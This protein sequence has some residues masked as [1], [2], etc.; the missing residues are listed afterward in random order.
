MPEQKIMIYVAS[1]SDSAAFKKRY[2]NT[3]VSIGTYPGIGKNG[4]FASLAAQIAKNSE[5]IDQVI[6]DIPSCA[7]V[8]DP[9]IVSKAM[10]DMVEAGVTRN[11]GFTVFTNGKMLSKGWTNYLSSHGV[12][13]ASTYDEIFNSIDLSNGSDIED[14]PDDYVDDSSPR[15]GQSAP[16][17]VIG[18]TYELDPF[19]DLGNYGKPMEY[20][21]TVLTSADDFEDP[22]DTDD[23][24]DMAEM[25]LHLD[26]RSARGS[27]RQVSEDEYDPFVT[28]DG[29]PADDPFSYL[30]EDEAPD[31][32]T[33]SQSDVPSS[34]DPHKQPRNP[35]EWYDGY[36]GEFTMG[37][38]SK[39]IRKYENPSWDYGEINQ[40]IRESKKLFGGKKTMGGR[41]IGEIE[42]DM[43]A[44]S[45]YIR[46]KVSQNGRYNVPTQSKIITVTS[47]VGAAGKT[48]ITTMIGAQL[49]WYFNRELLTNRSTSQNSRVLCLSLNEFDDIPVKG[50]GY[51]DND[52]LVER[53]PDA[54][55]ATLLQKIDECEGYPE[56]GDISGCFMTSPTNYVTYLPSLTMRQ[57]FEYNI[58]L[59]AD[60]YLKILNVCRRFFNF[61]V[62]DTPDVFFDQRNNLVSFAFNNSDVLC[63]VIQPDL[64]S[65]LHLFHFL[66]G[67]SATNGNVPIDR[68]KSMLVVNKIV[69]PGN[70]YIRLTHDKQL[71]FKDIANTMANRFY[72]ILP[73]PMGD[74]FQDKNVLFGYDPHIKKAA[75]DIADAVLEI[76]DNGDGTNQAPY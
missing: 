33:E 71:P 47:N 68:N 40:G 26:E 39:L 22:F 60:D 48:T 23:E 6:I 34:S 29:R 25:F 57:K 70:P 65:T 45:T 3:P 51:P 20:S 62:I 8:V 15:L 36:S 12:K 7:T 76:I 74:M 9:Q 11:V 30:S 75:A 24:L 10:S 56:W 41:L 64:K 5:H 38:I 35:D 19:A 73:L 43:L 21:D 67:L 18:K 53:Y 27:R 37:D 52:V 14:V 13:I 69:S 72:R 1:P 44:N 63:F 17:Q 46:D 66:D 28:V 59:T 49:V 32:E 58:D 42:P 4:F 50:I 55:I 54:N 61:I 31:T 16:E 2:A